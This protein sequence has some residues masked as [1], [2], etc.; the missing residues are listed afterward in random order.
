[1]IPYNRFLYDEIRA[2][3]ISK[4][5]QVFVPFIHYK[6]IKAIRLGD[7]FILTREPVA[8][9][10][11][12]NEQRIADASR[13]SVKFTRG[14]RSAASE[15]GDFIKPYS[16]RVIDGVWV[17]EFHANG[18]PVD[19]YFYRDNFGVENLYRFDQ[20]YVDTYKKSLNN[21]GSFIND[22]D[23]ENEAANHSFDL[24]EQCSAHNPQHIDFHLCRREIGTK[25]LSELTGM[26]ANNKLTSEIQEVRQRLFEVMKLIKG[27]YVSGMFLTLQVDE[28]S[29]RYY[30]T[31]CPWGLNER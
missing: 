25:M 18:V 30:Y 27:S 7:R 16:I 11:L 14:A 5:E 26:V 21:L 23:L 3:D 17:T 28:R 13:Y 8:I 9:W 4:F 24:C 6:A 31:E 1:M 20:S 19:R 22:I 15:I 29:E 2:L 10:D 12:K